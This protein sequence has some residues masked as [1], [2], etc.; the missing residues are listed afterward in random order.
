MQSSQISLFWTTCVFQSR[1]LIE[2]KPK[3]VVAEQGCCSL[4]FAFISWEYIH[5]SFVR[6][7]R[8][9]PAVFSTLGGAIVHDDNG[10]YTW[11]L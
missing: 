5:I 2:N 3:L 7:P 8:E 1:T 9:A 6:D 4:Y 10:L 11:Y